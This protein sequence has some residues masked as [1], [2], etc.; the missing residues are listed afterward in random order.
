MIN[1]NGVSSHAFPRTLPWTTDNEV[2]IC[3]GN[4]DFAFKFENN[5]FEI[6]EDGKSSKL[7]RQC[8]PREV[9]SLADLWLYSTFLHSF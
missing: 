5:S 4:D 7:R 8:S 1:L 2:F 3:Q 6:K 9:L